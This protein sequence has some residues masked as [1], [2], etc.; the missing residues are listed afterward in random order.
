MLNIVS[1]VGCPTSFS[2]FLDQENLMES[3][4]E[5]S[6]IVTKSLRLGLFLSLT[7]NCRMTFMLDWIIYMLSSIF[8]LWS[9]KYLIFCIFITQGA[10]NFLNC[11]TFLFI[12]YR[13]W[14]QLI[15]EL[16]NSFW[17]NRLILNHAWYYQMLMLNL[18]RPLNLLMAKQWI[19][20]LYSQALTMR[21]EISKWEAFGYLWILT[22]MRFLKKLFTIQRNLMMLHDHKWLWMS[23]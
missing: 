19:C 17:T 4:H 15:P 22:F 3:R 6:N 9:L 7:L 21:F 11:C 8:V 12:S 23:K 14:F 20:H 5:L 1:L 16:V 18:V 13:I 10:I 2:G